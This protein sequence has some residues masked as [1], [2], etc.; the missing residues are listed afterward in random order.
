MARPQLLIF[1]VN[2]TLL[3]LTELRSVL[4]AAMGGGERL[5]E[6]FFRLLHGSLVANVTDSFRS[7]ET[8]GVEALRADIAA[9][10]SRAQRGP[11]SG[12]GR[13]VSVRCPRTPTYQ[14]GLDRLMRTPAFA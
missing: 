8:I 7:F 1:D 2:E 6:W 4:A 13:R 12:A 14:P 9:S 3:D 10:G 11:G 5:A